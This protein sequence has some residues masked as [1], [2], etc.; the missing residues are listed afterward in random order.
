MPV[1]GYKQ[2]GNSQMFLQSVFFAPYLDI[3]CTYMLLTLAITTFY[4][5]FSIYLRSVSSETFP[6]LHAKYPFV[7]KVRPF[8]KCLR[9]FLDFHVPMS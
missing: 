6:T 9:L 4:P 5:W 8:Q 1:S 3:F 7:Q 2:N